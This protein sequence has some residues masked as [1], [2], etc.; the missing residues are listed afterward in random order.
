MVKTIHLPD[1]LHKKLKVYASIHDTT[2]EKVVAQIID[3]YFKGDNIEEIIDV[4]ED[5]SKD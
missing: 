4:I 5:N 3:E 2:I 1:D